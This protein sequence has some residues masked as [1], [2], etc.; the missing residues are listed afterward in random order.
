MVNNAGNDERVA[1]IVSKAL[2]QPPAKRESYLR[3][4]CS[5]DQELYRE[6]AAAVKLEERMGSFLLLPVLA[7]REFPRPF[8]TGQ[9]I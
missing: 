6:T 8:E 7:T 5:D 1:A 3:L 2:R 4:V 9:I